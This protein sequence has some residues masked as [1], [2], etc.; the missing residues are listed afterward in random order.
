MGPYH[1]LVHVFKANQDHK[2]ANCGEKVNF[3]PPKEM[4]WTIKTQPY[5]IPNSHQEFPHLVLYDPKPHRSVQTLFW[6]Q[7][8]EKILEHKKFGQDLLSTED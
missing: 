1:E 8:A 7:V 5:R 2:R 3:K 6:G 4:R